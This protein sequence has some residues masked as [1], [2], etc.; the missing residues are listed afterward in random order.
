[1]KGR[2][3]RH[4]F[5][6]LRPAARWQD[7]MISGNGV[8]ETKTFGHPRSETVVFNH[9]EILEPQLPDETSYPHTPP[10]ISGILGNV[11]ESLHSGDYQRASQIAFDAM[12]D[13]GYTF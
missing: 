10:E 13:S 12:T 7:A 9:E 11:R 1:M 3:P 6:S 2:I 8:I 4:G 5:G